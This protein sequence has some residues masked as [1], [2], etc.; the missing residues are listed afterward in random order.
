MICTIYHPMRG[1]VKVICFQITW[2]LILVFIVNP[3]FEWCNLCLEL[4]VMDFF[5]SINALLSPLFTHTYVCICVYMYVCGLRVH[6]C[7]YPLGRIWSTF[8]L[9][10][11]IF[12]KSKLKIHPI[13]VHLYLKIRNQVFSSF[14]AVHQVGT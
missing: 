3:L 11:F 10:K 8:I 14:F 6:V 7:V 5:M 4:L 13:H 12:R 9:F 1:D 2:F